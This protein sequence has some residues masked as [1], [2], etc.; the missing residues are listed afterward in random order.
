MTARLANKA[1]AEMLQVSNEYDTQPP[2][3]RSPASHYQTPLR[4]KTLQ[5]MVPH[6]PTEFP[7]F[8]MRATAI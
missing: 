7:T 8:A 6:R 2:S 1:F 5:I 3:L 4:L